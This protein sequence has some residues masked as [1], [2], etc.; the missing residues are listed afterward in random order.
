MAAHNMKDMPRGV[1]QE[2]VAEEHNRLTTAERE[3]KRA[4]ERQRK[5]VDALEQARADTQGQAG[6]VL[7]LLQRNKELQ[8]KLG[9]T[10]AQGIQLHMLR[11]T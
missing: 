8:T 7:A 1:W 4:R 2:L 11:D 10:T 3:A 5:C 9:A 6:E